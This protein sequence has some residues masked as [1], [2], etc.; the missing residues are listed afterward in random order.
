MKIIQ[1]ILVTV[2]LA[3]SIWTYNWPSVEGIIVGAL[4]H[5]VCS[6]ARK[7]PDNDFGLCM[8]GVFFATSV[9]TLLT[10]AATQ[11]LHFLIYD[12]VTLAVL[13]TVYPICK[14]VTTVAEYLKVRF[15]I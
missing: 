4:T 7:Q 12:A 8:I 11:T 14:I 6:I 10:V 15:F 13:F 2:G 9:I 1:A 3:Y 5:F